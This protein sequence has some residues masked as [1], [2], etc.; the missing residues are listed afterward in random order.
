MIDDTQENAVVEEA[1]E[2]TE[3]FEV[4]ENEAPASLSIQDLANIRNIIDVA[5]QRGAFKTN[6]FTVV[7]STYSRL[8]AFLESI[9]P[10]QTEEATEASDEATEE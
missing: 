2:A 9:T 10:A 7:G 8:N 3:K 4:S 6:E 5:S 1:T